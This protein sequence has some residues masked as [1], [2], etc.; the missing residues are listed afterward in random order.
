MPGL[1]SVKEHVIL[2]EISGNIIYSLCISSYS[3]DVILARINNICRILQKYKSEPLICVIMRFIKN[4]AK[5]NIM[6]RYTL[7]CTPTKI[8]QMQLKISK[9]L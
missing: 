7:T 8:N 5:W 2:S 3:I 6:A 4:N 1:F 9:F